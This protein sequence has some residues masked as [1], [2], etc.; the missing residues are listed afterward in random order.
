MASIVGRRRGRVSNEAEKRAR[1][2]IFYMRKGFPKIF[3][4]VICVR[5][6]GR[7]DA[8]PG[9]DSAVGATTRDLRGR[10]SVGQYPV[11]EDEVPC[12]ENSLRMRLS[13]SSN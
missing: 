9:V 7:D 4:D 5:S 13:F 8:E 10:L 3:A 11:L 6:L 2:V 12:M 1:F